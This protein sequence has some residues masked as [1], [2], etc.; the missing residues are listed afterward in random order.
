MAGLGGHRAQ[1]PEVKLLFLS[2]AR[3]Q[4]PVLIHPLASIVLMT[5]FEC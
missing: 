3:L 4:H 5:V 2:T 1:R